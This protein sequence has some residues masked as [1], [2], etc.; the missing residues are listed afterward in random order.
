MIHPI[1]SKFAVFSRR[2]AW[3]GIRSAAER[4]DQK[5]HKS[6]VSRGMERPTAAPACSRHYGRSAAYR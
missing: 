3:S 2:L 5:F 1:S 6:R 4:P